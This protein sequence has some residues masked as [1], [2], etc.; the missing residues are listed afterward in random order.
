M[1]IFVVSYVDS[2]FDC[3]ENTLCTTNF[4]LAVHHAFNYCKENKHTIISGIE[5]WEDDKLLFDYGHMNYDVINNIDINNEEL[6]YEDIKRDI[7][8]QLKKNKGGIK[9]NG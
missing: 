4:D 5:I 7:I 6:N 1:K 9:L 2:D 3:I 8:K